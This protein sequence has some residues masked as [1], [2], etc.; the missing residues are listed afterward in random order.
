MSIAE[1][2]T[3]RQVREYYGKRLRDRHDLRTSAC[4]CA[5]EAL[6]DCIKRILAEIDDEIL[7]KC[8]GC[9]SPIPPGIEGCTV[10]DLGCGA[11]RDA[12]VCSRLVGPEG[13]V[14]GVDMTDEQLAVARKHLDAHMRRWGYRRPNLEFR[15]GYIE[16]LRAAGIEDNS[17]DVIISNCVINLSPDK[18]RV[19]AEALRVLRPGGELYFSDVFAG[20]RIPAELRN[21][22]VLRG[23][24][25]SG[26]MYIEDFRRLLRELGILDYRI[27]SR[28]RLSIDDP[29]VEAKI[30]MVDF[31]SMT[32]RVFK[33]DSLEDLC[34]DYGQ[35]ATYL[36]T[37]PHAPH[38][39]V[40][41]DHHTFETHRPVRVCGNTASMLSE[42]RFAKHFVVHGDRNRHFGPFPCG[43][44]PSG[45][46]ETQCT[47]GGCC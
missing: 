39:F 23:E 26:A 9:G 17:I 11:G 24:C 37:I 27:V 13:R 15:Q 31:Y 16:D 29:Q 28:R 18:R 7:S 44:P 20:R 2:L 25:L 22:P 47:G 34:E 5:D 1:T 14:I 8:Y 36:G 3:H 19:F 33:L 41:D 42:T 35:S 32:V 6:P 21:D 38:R 30:G 45:A 46:L 10:L 40:L 12:Y 43:H 4:C